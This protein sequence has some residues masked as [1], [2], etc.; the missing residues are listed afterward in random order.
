MMIMITAALLQNNESH[1]LCNWTDNLI[2]PF[3]INM[4]CM[5]QLQSIRCAA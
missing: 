3:T 5:R 4:F 1:N 2:K